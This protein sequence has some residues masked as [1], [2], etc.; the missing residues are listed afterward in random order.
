MPPFA[1]REPVSTW[2]HVVGLVAAFPTTWIL[3]RATLRQ[4]AADPSAIAFKKGKVAAIAVFGFGMAACYGA[5]ALY[6][7]MNADT[8]TVDLLRRLDLVGIFLLIAGTF[9]PAAWALMRPSPRRI[10]TAVVWGISAAC[11]AAVLIGRS[12]PTWMATIIYLSLG[13][14]MVVCYMDIRRDYSRRTLR[15][16]PIGGAF[17]SVGAALNLLHVPT[18]TP[19]FGPHEVFHL[20]VLAGTAAHVTFLYRVAIPA[21]PQHSRNPTTHLLRKVQRVTIDA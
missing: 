2:T 12:F 20:F 4:V 17:Y 13:W 18:L 19:G 5:S 7:G 16:L 11:S 14:G 10:G 15:L 8:T 1:L 6:H 9:T 21:P 3:L